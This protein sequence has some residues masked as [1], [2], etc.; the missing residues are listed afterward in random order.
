[1]LKKLEEFILNID[2]KDWL[3]GEDPLS[4]EEHSM[5]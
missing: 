1:M 5:I 2:N 3:Y 4:D